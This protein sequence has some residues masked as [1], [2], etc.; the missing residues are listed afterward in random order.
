MKHDEPLADWE[1]E[2]LG[3]VRDVTVRLTATHHDGSTTVIDGINC[4]TFVWVY[5]RTEATGGWRSDGPLVLSV[6]G[7]ND[8][9]IY[10]VPSVKFY[11]TESITEWMKPA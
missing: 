7:E 4:E 10:Y 3:Y 11:T 5:L 6:E 8:G 1:A 2:L 9:L